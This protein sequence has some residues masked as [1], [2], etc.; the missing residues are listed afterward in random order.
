MPLLSW[1]ASACAAENPVSPRPPSNRLP[2]PPTYDL[3][4]EDRTT[5]ALPVAFCRSCMALTVPSGVS[6]EDAF[7]RSSS[8]SILR[9][10]FS[11]LFLP[12]RLP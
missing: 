4:P 12:D 3:L 10:F 11:V 5:N 2:K 7:C 6:V 9:S 8:S 1:T